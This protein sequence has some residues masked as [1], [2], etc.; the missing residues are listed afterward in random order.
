MTTNSASTSQTGHEAST[1]FTLP[2][3]L[4]DV[5][6]TA[7][8]TPPSQSLPTFGKGS[9]ITISIL[10]TCRFIHSEAQETL[11]ST[12]QVATMKSGTDRILFGKISSLSPPIPALLKLR[13]I[14]LELTFSSVN[15]GECEA[16]IVNATRWKDMLLPFGLALLR[17]RAIRSLEISLLNTNQRKVGAKRL[18]SDQ[19]RSE[20]RQLLEVFA[21]LPS[22]VSV[23][24]SG[25]DT[26]E[27]VIMLEGMREEYAG[28]EIPIE[29][30]AT[31]ALIL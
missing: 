16:G 11:Y 12:T 28:K 2:R 22:S 17:G 8:L 7:I 9:Q 1:F 29:D 15:R 10:L 30:W 13:R 27:Y 24:V 31:R 3:E 23:T 18:R 5:I 26:L 21:Y 20:V 19:M 4:R 6:Y 14:H 25:F